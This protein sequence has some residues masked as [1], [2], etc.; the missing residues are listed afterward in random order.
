MA[1]SG[2]APAQKSTPPARAKIQHAWFCQ[3]GQWHL[4]SY[5]DSSHALFHD[6]PSDGLRSGMT[7]S[8]LKYN[9]PFDTIKSMA[10]RLHLD[11]RPVSTGFMFKSPTRRYHLLLQ[12]YAD[13]SALV[14]LSLAT[15]RW[16]TLWHRELVAVGD[17]VLLQLHYQ[18]DSLL[19]RV[20]NQQ[21][22]EPAPAAFDSCKSVGL[23]CLE[24]AVRISGV[25]MSSADTL[26]VDALDNTPVINMHLER[27]FGAP[28]AP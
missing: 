19:C 9:R 2:C 15:D 6:A 26:V 11:K 25:S 12:A 23:L 17:S 8:V 28:A 27:M 18:N 4:L 14:L 16:D 1:F 10:A 3:I 13:S 7:V 5:P 21:L 24:G 20:D 22:Q